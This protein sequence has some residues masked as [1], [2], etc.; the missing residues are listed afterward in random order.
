MTNTLPFPEPLTEKYRPRRVRDFVGL[1]KVK[2]TLEPFI[3]QPFAHA[4]FF[5]GGSG[6]GK[7]ALVQAM[8]DEIHAQLH[9]VPSAECDLDRILRETAMCRYG[10]FDFEHGGCCPWHVL[11]IHE[12]DRMTP[13]AQI[14]LLSKMD[15]TAWPPQT[16]FIFTANSRL[17]LEPRFMSRCSVLEFDS[18]SMEG[19]LED[20]LAKIYK[21]EGGK[22][23]LDFAA[24]AK[25]TQYNVRDALNKLQ[26]ELLIGTNRKGL[27]TGELKIL[28]EHTHDC[29]KC[30]KPW[31][32]T[33]QKCKLPHVTV[34]PTCGGS[35]TIG[36]ERARKAWDTIRNNIAAELKKS[37]K[38]GKAA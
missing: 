33:V 10:A 6:L 14:A 12:A 16:I 27:P 15:S 30:H 32:C 37:K 1:V 26:V 7:T 38:K 29:E 22:H 36:T 20:Y 18:E 17:N 2:R 25:A 3:K 13:A 19:E 4:W 24:I 31:K 11:G 5:L 21:K 28:P 8:A 23:P 35:T 34:C 9:E